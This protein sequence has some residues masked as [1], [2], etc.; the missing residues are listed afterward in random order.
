MLLRRMRIRKKLILISVG[1]VFVVS[2]VIGLLAV[3]FHTKVLTRQIQ[4]SGRN[5]VESLE[6]SLKEPLL[7]ND[8]AAIDKIVSSFSR[9]FSILMDVVYRGDKTLAAYAPKNERALKVLEPEFKRLMDQP[10]D[11]HL[12]LYSLPDSVSFKGLS[13]SKVFI[14][15]RKVYGGRLAHIFVVMPTA[16]ETV[17]KTQKKLVFMTTG[18]SLLVILIAVV[19]ITVVGKDIADRLEYLRDKAEAI[20]L[21]DLDVEIEFVEDGDDIDL[22][23][24]ALERMRVSLKAAIDRLRKRR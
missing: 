2:F 6:T 19:L 16:F 4:D 1:S 17:I 11:E 21:G 7:A 13:Y 10:G 9:P 20:S 22:L 15:H 14:L 3:L 5:M 8:I 18:V 24:E 23:A 12:I